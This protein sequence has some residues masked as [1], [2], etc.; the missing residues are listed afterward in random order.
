MSKNELESLKKKAHNVADA[1]SEILSNCD[2]PVPSKIT[3]DNVDQEFMASLERGDHLTKEYLD[4]YYAE[5][6]SLD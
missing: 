1:V 2:M 3:V 6:D 5:I 4:S